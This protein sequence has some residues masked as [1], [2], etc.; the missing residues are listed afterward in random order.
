M[1]EFGLIRSG[2]NC[3]EFNKEFQGSQ[4]QVRPYKFKENCETIHS[5]G[6]FFFNLSITGQ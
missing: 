5:Q 1:S 4:K 6:K 3:T 2:D